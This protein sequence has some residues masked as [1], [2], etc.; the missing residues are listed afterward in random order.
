M[1]VCLKMQRP[2]VFWQ[3]FLQNWSPE[4]VA[5]FFFGGGLS[6]LVR[7]PLQRDINLC[8]L[9]STNAGNNVSKAQMFQCIIVGMGC[10]LNRETFLDHPVESANLVN[11]RD[12]PQSS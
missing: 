8:H 1:P 9:K 7:K 11:S 5:R 3:R 2:S 10:D 4:F 12:Y 6:P